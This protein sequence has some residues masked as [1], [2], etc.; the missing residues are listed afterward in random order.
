MGGL[1]QGLGGQTLLR[2]S[3]TTTSC[4]QPPEL[5]RSPSLEGQHGASPHSRLAGTG[6]GRGGAAPAV[7]GRD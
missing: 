5:I 3:S 2:N 4:P 6:K 7:L 1:R